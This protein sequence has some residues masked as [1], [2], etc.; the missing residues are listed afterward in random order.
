MP[1]VLGSVFGMKLLPF[2]LSG[3]VV[4]FRFREGLGK[5][6]A[7]KNPLIDFHCA[8][9]FVGRHLQSHAGQ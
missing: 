7:D 9:K 2:R 1:V 6:S 5:Q 8:S 3:R 4:D